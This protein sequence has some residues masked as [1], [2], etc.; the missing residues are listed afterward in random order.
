[1]KAR[2]EK[3]RGPFSCAQSGSDQLLGH[4]DDA[5]TAA[6]LAAH[7]DGAEVRPDTE[8][9]ELGRMAVG[10]CW[11]H[12]LR[13]VLVRREYTINRPLPLAAIFAFHSSVG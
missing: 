11:R 8:D 7:V 1:M 3:C 12:Y 5:F 6:R 10:T 4:F 13:I 2:P 9:D